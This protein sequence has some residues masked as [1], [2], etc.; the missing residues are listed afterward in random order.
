MQQSA[1]SVEERGACDVQSSVHS[2]KFQH[3][4]VCSSFEEQLLTPSNVLVADDLLRAAG[5]QK[6][7]SKDCIVTGS[8]TL[9]L[10][11]SDQ[12]PGSLR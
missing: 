4:N 5:I 9:S 7:L 6:P 8:Q 1:D 11:C 2:G 3:S 10:L 12:A